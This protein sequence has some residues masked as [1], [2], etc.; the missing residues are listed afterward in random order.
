MGSKITEKIRA[1]SS[2]EHAIALSVA[3]VTAVGSVLFVTYNIGYVKGHDDLEAMYIKSCQS[4]VWASGMNFPGIKNF[5]HLNIAAA[6]VTAALCL[7]WRS[8]ISYVLSALAA[9]WIGLVFVWWYLDSVAFLRNLEIADYTQLDAPD[10]QHIGIFRGAVWW[11]MVTLVVAG[12]LFLWVM[13]VLA[14]VHIM[15]RSEKLK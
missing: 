13:K 2:K 12:T 3:A 11:D 5:W 8:F 1:A 10:F 7:W 15:L 14:G 9:V 6:I 4:Y